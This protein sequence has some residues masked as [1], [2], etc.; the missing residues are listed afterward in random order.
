MIF[1]IVAARLERDTIGHDASIH[2]EA[3][4]EICFVEIEAIELAIRKCHG[5]VDSRT[6]C[7]EIR[8]VT[9]YATNLSAERFRRDRDTI[10]DACG[11]NRLCVT[12]GLD[13]GVGIHCVS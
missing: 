5:F 6:C 9:T 11:P 8:E 13:Y 12:E 3:L 4:Q 10:A 1:V 7:R 2:G